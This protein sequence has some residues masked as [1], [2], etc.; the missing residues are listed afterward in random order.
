VDI[1]DQAADCRGVVV[2]REHRR[3]RWNRTNGCDQGCNSG[4]LWCPMW[5]EVDGHDVH[6]QRLDK[7]VGSEIGIPTVVHFGII[8][9]GR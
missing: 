7:G 3:N 2:A 6:W 5:F 9:S 8:V 1:V 4:P